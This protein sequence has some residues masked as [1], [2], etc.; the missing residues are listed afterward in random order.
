[1]AALPAQA[2]AGS[3][4]TNDIISSNLVKISAVYVIVQEPLT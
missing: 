1:M 4:Y 2:A 3:R